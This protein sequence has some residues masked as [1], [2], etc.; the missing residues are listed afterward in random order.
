MVGLVLRLG[1]CTGPTGLL[2]ESAG[3]EVTLAPATP[4]TPVTPWAVVG[5]APGAGE[6]QQSPHSET[7]ADTLGLEP[8]L[9]LWNSTGSAK[10][11]L[12]VDPAC[13][14]LHAAS[15]KRERER[16]AM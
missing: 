9:G 2:V 13:T 14:W 10:G 12:S 3:L 6:G 4:V 11:F 1:S 16:T 7:Q 8:T 5:A 15:A